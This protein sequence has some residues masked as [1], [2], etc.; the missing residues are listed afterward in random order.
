[1]VQES[2][3]GGSG[4][5]HEQIIE[6]REVRALKYR[7]EMVAEGSV[8]VTTLVVLLTLLCVIVDERLLVEGGCPLRDGGR[9]TRVGWADKGD[10][11]D[12][13]VLCRCQDDTKVAVLVLSL[14][15]LDQRQVCGEETVC[16][17][18]GRLFRFPWM[19]GEG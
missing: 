17:L 7:E 6:G 11:T 15:T 4:V 18:Y 12:E 2:L 5:A 10:L 3:H 13:R 14:G 1:M 8:D 16:V 19:I 9:S